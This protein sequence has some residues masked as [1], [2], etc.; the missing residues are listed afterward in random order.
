MGRQKKDEVSILEQQIRELKALNRS[1]LRRLKKVDRNFKEELENEKREVEKSLQ[2]EAN[3]LNHEP[4]QR[5]THC[6]K[7]TITQVDIL[8][9]KFSRCDTCDWRSK[10]NKTRT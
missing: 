1:L 4:K 5:C 10:S 3:E 2:E 6:G 9:R 8:G 7:G